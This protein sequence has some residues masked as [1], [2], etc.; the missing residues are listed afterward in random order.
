MKLL[1]NGLSIVTMLMLFSTIVCGFWIKSNQIVEKSS[2]QFHAVMGSISAIL[3]II[4]LI[5]LMVTIKKVA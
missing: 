3:T 1:I 2:I 4:L 5:V